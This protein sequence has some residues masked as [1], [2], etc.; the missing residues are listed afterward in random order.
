MKLSFEYPESSGHKFFAKWEK[1]V[2]K[3]LI[4]WTY[5]AS[6]K[7]AHILKNSFW[8]IFDI[9]GIDITNPNEETHGHVL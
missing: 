4:A 1:D 5:V 3:Q 2:W 7:Y 8:C 9:I 6:G